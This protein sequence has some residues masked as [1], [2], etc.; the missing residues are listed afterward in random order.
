MLKPLGTSL[1]A[2]KVG[3]CLFSGN[4]QGGANSANQVYGSGVGLE[5]LSPQKATSTAKVSS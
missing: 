5:S 1:W 2:L 3:W 4:H